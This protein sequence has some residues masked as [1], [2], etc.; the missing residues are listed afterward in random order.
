MHIHYDY[1]CC[2]Y[3][4]ILFVCLK[5]ML[6]VASGSVFLW[7]DSAV[8]DEEK[9]ILQR[10][11]IWICQVWIFKM[12]LFYFII[13]IQMAKKQKVARRSLW[14]SL[15]VILC[16]VKEDMLLH[17][18]VVFWPIGATLPSGQI[19]NQCSSGLMGTLCFRSCHISY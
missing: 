12:V 3:M 10:E 13:Y 2:C 5:L 8:C 17:R 14:E 7:H 16:R 4:S 9:L 6:Y 1:Y 19:I 18:S 15:K 11:E